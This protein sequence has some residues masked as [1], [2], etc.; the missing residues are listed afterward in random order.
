MTDIQVTFAVIIAIE[1]LQNALRAGDGD[2]FELSAAESR[3]RELRAQ[4]PPGKGK[5]KG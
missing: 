3:L 4:Q 1:Q 2:F 5:G